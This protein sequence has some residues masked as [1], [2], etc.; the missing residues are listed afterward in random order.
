MKLVKL[1]P[2]ADYAKLPVAEKRGFYDAA[3]DYVAK[4]PSALNDI[5]VAVLFRRWVSFAGQL[6]DQ[7]W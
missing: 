6:F 7:Y 1:V 5:R 2:D 4:L 3:C